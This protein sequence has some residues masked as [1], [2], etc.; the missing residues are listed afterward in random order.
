M[1]SSKD[2]AYLLFYFLSSVL[3]GSDLEREQLV[4]YKIYNEGVQFMPDALPIM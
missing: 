1:I 4:I 2:D 3:K